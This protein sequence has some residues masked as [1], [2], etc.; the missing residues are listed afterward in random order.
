MKSPSTDAVAPQP[1]IRDREPGDR[2]P[3]MLRVPG[4]RHPD[5]GP[6]A[7]VGSTHRGGQPAPSPRRSPFG[8]EH[9][10]STWFEPES[11]KTRC[12]DGNSLEAGHEEEQEGIT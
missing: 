9:G 11:S 4:A 5:H 1:R 8:R 6:G 2:V 10:M 12:H 3:P 7:G